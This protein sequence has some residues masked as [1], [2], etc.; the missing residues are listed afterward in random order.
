[1]NTSLIQAAL[2]RPKS[3]QF[4]NGWVGHLP[5][6]AWVIKELA[7]KIFVELGT[8]SGNSY[9]SFCQAVVEGSL[10]TKCY[11]VD[12]WEGDEHAG[13]YEDDVF[14]A[15][16]AHNTASYSGFSRLLRMTFDD[17]TNYFSDNTISLL[18]IDGLHTYEAVKHDFET[19]LPKLTEDAVVIFHDINVRERGFGVWRLWEELQQQY[20][21]HIEFIHSHGLGVL[22]LNVVSQNNVREWLKPSSLEQKNVIDFF[23]ALGEMQLIRYETQDLKLHATNLQNALNARLNNAANID[24][25]LVNLTDQISQLQNKQLEYINQIDFLNHQL[26]T[27]ES[28]FKEQQDLNIQKAIE[29]DIHKEKIQENQHQITFL[30][31]KIQ[32]QDNNADNLNLTIIELQNTINHLNNI[33]A[34]VQNQLLEQQ[35]VSE[36]DRQQVIELQQKLQNKQTKVEQLT[37]HIN[38]KEQTITELVHSTS[39]R[40]TQPV[41]KIGHQ[42]KRVKRIFGLVKPALKRGKG[43]SNTIGIAYKLYKAEGINGIRRGLAF[44]ENKIAIM[45]VDE[46]GGFDRNDY[47]E[48][49]RRYDTLNDNQRIEMKLRILDFKETPKISVV[50]PTYNPKEEWLVEAIESVRSQIYTNWELCIADD[51]SNHPEVSAILK[52][53]AKLDKRIK[54]KIRLQNGHISAASNS[55]LE[56]ATGAW[57]ALMDHDDLLTEHALYWVADAINN[58]P[59]AQLIYSDEDKLDEQGIRKDPYFKCDWNRDLFYSHNMISHLGVYKAQILKEI[60]GFRV[61]MEGSQDYDLALR[62]IEKIN[63]HQIHHI[64]RVL[65]NWRVHVASTAQSIEAKP[66]AQI[67]TEKALNEH[68]ERI[69]VNAKAEIFAYGNKIKYELPKISPLVSIIIPTKNGL[70]LIK[71]CVESILNKTTYQNYEIIIVDNGSDDI[72]V[73]KYFEELKQN[74]KIKVIHDDRPFNYSALNNSAVN[75]AKGEFI[76]LLNNDIE[77]ITPNWLEEMMGLAIQPNVGAVGARLWYPNDTLQH[78]GVIIG[79]GGVG[80]HAHKH[81]PKTQGGYFS[82]AQLTQAFSVVTAACLIVKKGIFEQVNGLNEKNLIIAF[83]DVDLCLKLLKAG[84]RNVWTP[85]AELYHHESATRGYEDTVEKQM[86]FKLEIDYMINTWGDILDKDKAYSPNLTLVHEDFSYAWPPRVAS[87]TQQ[88]N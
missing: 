13:Q 7:P 30:N 9:F 58:N 41:R 38:S 31:P 28:N 15:V 16:N 84:Y 29:I 64:P 60:N 3:V 47:T 2:F 5:F 10:L 49:L 33:L 88:I 74:S 48:W 59:D 52:K 63:D 44:V 79:I 23:A 4:P 69:G 68:F 39:W 65:Y 53:Y 83:N 14:N 25:Q 37:Q 40:L 43:I 18:H 62:F 50:M 1:M 19:W 73:L 86:R 32:E 67:A 75:K 11:A 87:I 71:M 36:T 12:T 22:Q 6:A 27:Q 20:P 21:N 72:V 42:F 61:G 51:A 24:S 54:I 80:G 82:R 56:L 66:Y 45:P 46:S 85:F 70:S 8:H 55:A 17:A 34:H 35:T 57:V 76:A 78:G 26:Q 77:V 81:L